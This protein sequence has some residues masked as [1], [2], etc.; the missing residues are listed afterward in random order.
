MRFGLSLQTRIVVML[1]LFAAAVAG[2]MLKLPSGFRHIDK[3]L[4]TAFYFFA[5]A[6][7]N[8]LFART[9]LIRHA[10]IFAALAL[11]GMAIEWA[12]AYSNRFF[13]SR[14]HG[15][16]DPE[17]LQANLYGLIAFSALWL[18]VVLVILFSKKGSQTSA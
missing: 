2:F 15:R 12:Q 1:L 11:F 7:L 5:A 16:F 4:H 14:I 13:R 8:V 3:E 9:S 10:A 17:D 6:F 18:V